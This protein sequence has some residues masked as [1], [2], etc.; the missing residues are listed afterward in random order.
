MQMVGLQP[1]KK[2]YSINEDLVFLRP[3]S[4]VEALINAAFCRRRTLRLLV[5]TKSK[6]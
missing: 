5:A 3:F 4:E 6:E 1:G 2:V